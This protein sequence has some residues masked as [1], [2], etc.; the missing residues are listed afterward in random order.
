MTGRVQPF[1][2]WH[3]WHLKERAKSHDGTPSPV[4]LPAS[5]T[6]VE[7]F[8]DFVAS[9]C[10]DCF[11]R[12][13][14]TTG[15][16]SKQF[17]SSIPRHC[18]HASTLPNFVR[19]VF[20]SLSGTVTDLL[21]TAS[22]AAN[23]VAS[24]ISRN[25]GTTDEDE[26]TREHARLS[27]KSLIDKPL[28]TDDRKGTDFISRQVV[29]DLE[30]VW[31]LLFGPPRMVRPGYGGMQGLRLLAPDP[32]SDADDPSPTT[33]CT[34]MVTAIETTWS[35]ADLSM[36]G[37][38]RRAGGSGV[39]VRLNGRPFTMEDAEHPACG[40]LYHGVALTLPNRHC[41]VPSPSSPHCHPIP[42]FGRPG[43][44]GS[45]GEKL[46]TISSDAVRAWRESTSHEESLPD[47]FLLRDDVAIKAAPDS[48]PE[49]RCNDFSS[50]SVFGEDSEQDVCIEGDDDYPP[51]NDVPSI[52]FAGIVPLNQLNVG[53]AGNGG[54]KS[55]FDCNTQD[56]LGMNLSDSD[57]L[58]SE[59][60]VECTTK[61]RH[62]RKRSRPAGNGGSKSLFDCNIQDDLGMNLS[63]SDYLPSEESVECTTKPRHDRKCS[64]KGKRRG[65]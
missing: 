16:T 24:D 31:D 20:L 32:S 14:A 10:T 64:R 55:L 11:G 57:Y 51:G 60:S 42:L 54:S 59:E 7:S 49:P 53:P 18:R 1:H 27:I 17:A 23:K 52:S 22:K 34:A 56:D 2:D 12:P 29:L 40:A 61:P 63:D 39:F 46:F 5:T 50:L 38:E 26:D 30:E 48:S 45:L 9:T 35:E 6:D 33:R 19:S 37:L 65:R 44:L 58:P 8:L 4:T 13:H 36:M 28:P 3:Q 25:A 47:V 62:D 21:A 43:Y 41:C 15:W